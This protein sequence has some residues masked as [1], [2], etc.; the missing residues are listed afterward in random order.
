VTQLEQELPRIKDED[1][2]AERQRELTA[3]QSRLRDGDF[4]V[5]DRLLVTVDSAASAPADSFTVKEGRVI[6]PRDMPP[7]SL[8]GVL[9]SELDDYLTKQYG[10]VLR[11]PSVKA[12]PLLRIAVYGP[13]QNPGFYSFPFDALVSDVIMKAGGPGQ[14]ADLNRSYVQ[15]GKRKVVEEREVQKAIVNGLT[16]QDINVRPG[17][18]LVV[19]AQGSKNWTNT[20]RTIA[21]GVT[22]SLTLY[23]LGKRL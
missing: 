18:A 5:G 23:S 3:I 11:N 6:E 10:R 13:V 8:Q 7:I 19:G 1:D 17:D 14:S 12:T 16:L 22:L 9:R 2:R 20:L 4:E 21:I 15:R